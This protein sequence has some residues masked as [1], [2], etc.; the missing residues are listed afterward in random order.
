MST[1]NFCE[2]VWPRLSTMCDL[3]GRCDSKMQTTR[4]VS[5]S[6]SHERKTSLVVMT[7]GIKALGRSRHTTTR[8]KKIIIERVEDDRPTTDLCLENH[9]VRGSAW[10]EKEETPKTEEQKKKKVRIHVVE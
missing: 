8:E 6:I 4:P 10:S 1:P 9:V 2:I 5:L 7:R 3:T